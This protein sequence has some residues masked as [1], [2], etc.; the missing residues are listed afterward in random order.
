MLNG[1][2]M[3]KDSASLR[4]DAQIRRLFPLRQIKCLFPHTETYLFE[5]F[6]NKCTHSIKILAR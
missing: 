4:N 1:V 6:V 2:K 5:I 3:F